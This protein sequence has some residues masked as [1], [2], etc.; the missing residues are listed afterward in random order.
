[1]KLIANGILTISVADASRGNKGIIVPKTLNPA[2]GKESTRETGFNELQWGEST[3][4]YMKSIN[5]NLR[6]HKF[7]DIIARAKEFAKTSRRVKDMTE[8]A[9]SINDNDDDDVLMDLSSSE[10]DS[11][12]DGCTSQSTL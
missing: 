5:K 10:E 7:D 6:D 3:R 11:E 1:M 4:F 2:T 12:I 9:P 8:D